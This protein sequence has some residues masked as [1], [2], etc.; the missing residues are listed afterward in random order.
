MQR[1]FTALAAAFVFALSLLAPSG[2][3]AQHR[4]DGHYRGDRYEHH[5]RHRHRHQHYRH[6]DDDAVA[7]GVIGLVLG[8]TI[9]ALASQPRYDAPPPRCTSDYRRCAPP[10]GYGDDRYY[11]ESGLEGGYEPEY[12]DESAYGRDYGAPVDR[13]YRGAA[14]S[15]EQCTRRERQWDR[16]ANRYVVVDVP[17]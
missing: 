11:D 14:A 4:R 13:S 7:A 5:D 6:D 15:R 1:K 16:Y 2:A 3:V 8:L 9:G 10:Q 17:C 12:D